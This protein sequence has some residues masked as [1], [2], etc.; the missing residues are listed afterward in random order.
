MEVFYVLVSEDIE[1]LE[2]ELDDV[3]FDDGPDIIV[4]EPLR[5]WLIAHEV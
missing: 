5:D 1:L 4:L 2:D 3:V